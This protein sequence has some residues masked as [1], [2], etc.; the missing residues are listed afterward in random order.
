VRGSAAATS[1]SDHRLPPA[2]DSVFQMLDQWLQDGAPRDPTDSWRSPRSTSGPAR[3]TAGGT[4]PAGRPDQTLI[5]DWTELHL[6]SH[7][8]HMVPL[9]T[10]TTAT[11]RLD[12]SELAHLVARLSADKAVDVVRAAHPT[13][14]A[15]ALHWLQPFIVGPGPTGWSVRPRQTSR[16]ASRRSQGCPTRRPAIASPST[17]KSPDRSGPSPPYGF[18]FSR[19]RVPKVADKLNEKAVVD[20]LLRHGS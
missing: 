10:A 4:S 6:T 1:D 12:A 7:R 15:A 16:S 3:Y 17:A 5:V 20:G 19:W 2:G 8:G 14:A 11:H 9:A 18:P 13:H